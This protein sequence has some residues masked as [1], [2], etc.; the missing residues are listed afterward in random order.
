MAEERQ[1]FERLP[2]CLKE[3]IES[4][5]RQVRYRRRVRR[6]VERE[7]TGHFVDALGDC[8]SEQER[9]KLGEK[10]V[11]EFGQAKVLAKLIRRG[12]KRCRPLWKK[13]M[14][15]SVQT[16]LVGIVL[17]GVY[18]FWFIKGKPT[19]RVDYLAKMNEMARPEIESEQ[20]G[21]HHLEKAN[22]LYVDYKEIEPD[23]P[24]PFEYSRGDPNRIYAESS[25]WEFLDEEKTFESLS[26][27]QRE[28]L[29]KWLKRNEPA[30]EEF[31]QIAKK[32]YCWTEY[33]H[34]SEGELDWM[35][36]IPLPISGYLHHLSTIGVWRVRLAFSKKQYR[37][38]ID[39]CLNIIR[40][41]RHWQRK[42]ITLIEQMRGNIL[43]RIGHQG[44]LNCLGQTK[45]TKNE[46]IWLQ[47]EL[48]GIYG[49]EFPLIDCETERLLFMDT[50]Q[51]VFT[52]GGPGGGHV[53]PDLSNFLS[54]YKK[55]GEM[56]FSLLGCIFHA[57]RNETV[58]QGKKIYSF[59]NQLE[60]MTP[61]ER[62]E[63]KLSVEEYLSTLPTD[64]YLLIH[65]CT[66]S[67]LD[68][69]IDLGH[70]TKALHQAA[71]TVLALKRYAIENIEFPKTLDMLTRKG[72][73]KIL[74]DDPYS[75]GILRYKQQGEDFILY[76]LGVDFDDDEGKKNPKDIWSLWSERGNNGDWVF[77][78]V[79]EKEPQRNAD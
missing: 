72:Y 65:I 59:I 2:G 77:W 69:G 47:I 76:S 9:N 70:Q 45:F 57:R 37:E 7:L 50:V 15:R 79:E 27:E 78:P 66:P 53:I 1:K 49:G 64:K 28:R 42:N 35:F 39:T 16:F 48:R 22:E 41:G 10:L 46:L 24:T 61:Y 20:N 75:D 4:V 71:L 26:A 21:W 56:A 30:W 32:P 68:K 54:V 63:K 17:C 33:M 38:A 36:A 62:Y 29:L 58:V 12:K 25:K 67:S 5:I 44:I 8:E 73:I 13:V 74:P 52:E 19:V 11:A 34:K 55:N 43:C 14:I 51:Q 40:I 23:E 6:E 3:Y 60:T 18:S 31:V